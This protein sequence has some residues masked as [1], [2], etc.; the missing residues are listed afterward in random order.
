MEKV[1]RYAR[2]NT[3][4]LDGGIEFKS[5]LTVCPFPECSHE[6]RIADETNKAG[7]FER[8]QDIRCEHARYTFDDGAIE[9]AKGSNMRNEIQKNKTGI[10][11]KTEYNQGFVAEL[12]ES[13]PPSE[14]KWDSYHKV[15]GVSAEYADKATEIYNR[16]FGDTD[17]QIEKEIEQ[18][19]ANQ[20]AIL[21]MEEHINEAIAA[22]DDAISRYSFQSKSSIKGRMCRDMA[23]LRHAL[24]NA[25]VPVDELV[26]LQV[27]GMA[28]AIRLLRENSINQLTSR[29]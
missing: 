11:L 3:G 10:T 21:E 9:F 8:V 7:F 23:L 14:R 2:F 28:A 29:N 19:K 16:Y 27:R 6:I 25:R 1:V 24:N 26:E 15:W 22:L 13:I 20:A 12:K 17:A 4:T 5:W 18:I